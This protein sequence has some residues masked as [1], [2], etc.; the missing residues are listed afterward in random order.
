ME[1]AMVPENKFAVG[2]NNIIETIGRWC[3]ALN[4]V[5]IAAIIIQV[6][7]RYAFGLGLVQLEELQ[8]HLYAVNVIFGMAYCLSVDSHIRL[9]L[10]HAKLSQRTR[11]WIEIFGIIILLMPLIYVI[12]YHSIDFL[13]E[14]I[15]TNERSDSP[16]GLCCRWIPKGLIPIAMIMLFASATARVVKGFHY[17]KH[18]KKGA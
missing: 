6:V 4:V 18:T 10:V 12:F 9:D 16:V 17:L 7:L 1:S 15:R 13:W 5:L 8:W 14:A 2:L 3:S 11:E